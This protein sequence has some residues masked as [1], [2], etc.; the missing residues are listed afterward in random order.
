MNKLLV[1]AIFFLVLAVGAF[2][3]NYLYLTSPGTSGDIQRFVIPED[4]TGFNFINTLKDQGLIKN[5]KAFGFIYDYFSGAGSI[6][7]GGYYLAQNMN[8]WQIL[9][10]ITGK[11]DML[12]VTTS[13]CLRKEQIGEIL[14]K[15]LGWTNDQLK[16]WDFAYANDQDPYF[17]GVY[18]PDTYLIPVA[19]N[20]ANVAGRYIS[21][22]NNKIALLSGEMTDK[23][24][25]WTTAL[26]VAS[27]IAREAAGPED[28]KLIS[29][30]IWNRL[31]K[32]MPLQID[33]TMAYTLGRNING[34]WWSTIDT[35]QKQSTSPYNTYKVKGLPPT[36]ICS[37]SV[38][39]IQAA[40][41]PE[42]TDCIFYLHDTNK[43]IHCAKTY[44]EHL[45]NIKKYLD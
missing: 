1:L 42:T 5:E 13:F 4:A 17:E 10:K 16:A 26:K 43:Q 44:A 24:I 2:G 22:F 32:N 37:P 45:Q 25:K 40:I 18:Y 3:F 6:S 27:L 38:D 19:E 15:D 31:N 39:A 29:G 30:I 41:E 12:W 11:P 28:M 23:N 33:A 36:P 7:P 8:A 34:S 20:G 14:Q 21:N 35:A 9:R